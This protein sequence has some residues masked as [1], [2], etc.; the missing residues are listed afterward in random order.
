MNA[1]T[2][3]QT[4]VYLMGER[5]RE[6]LGPFQAR[7]GVPQS[8]LTQLFPH[9]PWTHLSC[10]YGVYPSLPDTYHMHFTND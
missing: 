5:S 8:A 10:L 6:T 4:G 3:H 7:A 2:A 1:A 9:T